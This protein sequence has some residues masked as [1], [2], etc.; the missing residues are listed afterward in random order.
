M[1]KIF[2]INKLGGK[3]MAKP[4]KEFDIFKDEELEQET[5]TILGKIGNLTFITSNYLCEQSQNPINENIASHIDFVDQIMNMCTDYA[6]Q[7]I[8]ETDT[9]YSVSMNCIR[10]ALT[11]LSDYLTI[12]LLTEELQKQVTSIIS[13]CFD[14]LNQIELCSYGKGG[15]RNTKSR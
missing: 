6:T 8:P 11:L 5:E 2:S 1:L 15:G 4:N 12:Y 3:T 7:L 9:K 10:A 13:I 14:Y